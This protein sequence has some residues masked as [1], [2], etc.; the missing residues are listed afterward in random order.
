VI[1]VFT[2]PKVRSQRSISRAHTASVKPVNRTFAA[3]DN[4]VQH[5][6][7]GA[8][9]DVSVREP[10]VYLLERNL[11]IISHYHTLGR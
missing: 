10:K 7:V 4:A 6:D 9:K 3:Q 11:T 1:T 5:I 2:Q 8:L